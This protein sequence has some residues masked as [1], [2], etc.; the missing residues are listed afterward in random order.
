MKKHTPQELAKIYTDADSVDR[1]TFAEMRSNVLIVAGEHYA[2]KGSK[3]W[4][5]IKDDKSLSE[6]TKLRI[7]KNHTQKI[8]KNIANQIVAQA[9]GVMAAPQNEKERKDQKAAELAQSVWL[10]GKRKN[11]LSEKIPSW[12]DSMVVISEVHTKTFFDPNKGTLKG[13]EQEVDDN[14]YLVF[15]DRQGQKTLQPADMMGQPHE[16]MQSKNPIMSGQLVIKDYYGFNVLRAPEAQTFEES[17]YT[18]IRSMVDCDEVLAMIP[19]DKKELREKVK[20]E[21]DGTYQIFDTSSSNYST[22]TNQCLYKEFYFR[23]CLRYPKGY[24]YHMVAS[25]VLF[26][27]ELPGGAWPLNSAC[28]ETIPTNPRGIGPVRVMKPIQLEINRTSSKIAETH[29][30]LGDDKVIMKKGSKLEPGATLPGMRG[31]TVS[32]PDP[33]ILPGRDG[34][35]Y[36]PWLQMNIDELYKIMDQDELNAPESGQLDPMAMLFRSGQQKQKF[37]RN[38]GRFERFLSRQMEIYLELARF[39]LSEEDLIPIV[40]KG[41]TVNISEFK[42]TDPLCYLI[43]AEAISE[44]IESRVGKQMA[45]QAVLQYGQQLSREEIGQAI[46]NMP[47]GNGEQLF[48]DLTLEYDNATNVILA[49][50]RGQQP[51]FNARDKHEYMISKIS[52]RMR[53]PDYEL[54]APEIKAAY[55]DRIAMHQKQIEANAEQLRLMESKLIPT[56]GPLVGIDFYVADPKDPSK[57]RRAK[58]P[59]D[60]VRDLIEKL[61]QQ[62]TMLQIEGMSQEN[63]AEMAGHLN[64]SQAGGPSTDGVAPANQGANEMAQGVGHGNSGTG[65]SGN[66]AGGRSQVRPGRIAG[67]FDKLG[68][69]AG[70][71]RTGFDIRSIG[72]AASPDGRA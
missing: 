50:D 33:T 26:E 2:K 43:K 44:D 21:A 38:V 5:R 66:H 53:E 69:L 24:F 40:G 63:M 7:V 31:V 62:G 67:G 4:N 11:N 52:K 1:N 58:L 51:I 10:D 42:N 47:Y 28:Y 17:P 54:L 71:S 32:G 45:M 23:P 36:V 14:G 20:K 16:P 59:T 3:F 48:A 56:S 46:R 70:N 39:Y 35:Q 13:Y 55:E 49:L 64:S 30:S 61:E 41:E 22:T 15:K 8:T 19:E 12:V 37:K 34:A 68:A 60:A 27:G 72:S 29:I 9:P 25:E 65:F 57:S 6:E 18:I